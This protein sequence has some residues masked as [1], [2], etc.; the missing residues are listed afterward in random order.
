MT[1]EPNVRFAVHR[2]GNGRRFSLEESDE[3]LPWAPCARTSRSRLLRPCLPSSAA[4][5]GL[6]AFV[7]ASRIVDTRADSVRHDLTRR[8][9]GYDVS[10]SDHVQNYPSLNARCLC[11][12]F[13]EVS[14][15][16]YAQKYHAYT[17][18]RISV[19]RLLPVTGSGEPRPS[20]CA[21]AVFVRTH[22]RI[23]LCCMCDER[24][25]FRRLL[26]RGSIDATV[27][28]L[29]LFALTA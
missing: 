14:V 29:L 16:E 23:S 21:L 7:A 5:R 6:R 15:T 22:P 19:A 28:G 8:R 26:V 2:D 12:F 18:T 10:A 9:R 24:V 4:R 25:S 17:P 13:S 20:P 3:Q 1:R 11:N 27:R